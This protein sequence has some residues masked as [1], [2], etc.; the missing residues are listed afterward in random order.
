MFNRLVDEKSYEFENLEEKIN[1][2][3]L[4]HKYKTE[5][6]SPKDFRDCQN[7]I[8]LFINLRDGNVNPRELLKNQISF[9]SYLGETRKRKSKVKIKRPNNCNTKY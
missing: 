4:I 7:L 3:S 2:N 8:N 6:R 5:G 1:H 9:K